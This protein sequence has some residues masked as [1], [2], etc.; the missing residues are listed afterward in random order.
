MKYCFDID[1]TIC[2]NTYGKYDEAKPFPDVIKKVNTLYDAGNKIIFFTARGTTTGIDWSE[3]TKSQLVAW[4][5]KH[6]EI[7][8]NKPDAD[9]FI[10]DKGVDIIDFMN[11]KPDSIFDKEE[12]LD[13]TYTDFKAPKSGYPF[14]L[15]KHIKKN[16]FK[17]EGTVLD[18]G[19]GFGEQLAGFEAHG[20]KPSGIDLSPSVLKLKDKFDVKVFD[21]ENSNF[22][23]PENHFDFVF[24][25][26][27]IEHMHQ[28][29]HLFD[30]ALKALKPKGKAVIMTPSWEHNMW[31]PFYIDHTHVTPFTKTS[32]EDLFV[33]SGF[34]NVEVLHFYQLPFVW[35]S[36]IFRIIPK[37]ISKLPIKYSPYYK[38][39]ILP[40]ELNKLVRFSNEVMLFGYGEKE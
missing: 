31:G 39:T 14:K 21:L 4:G 22:P 17:T 28:P 36:P 15:I 25:K 8:L 35:Q 33:M 16:Y 29:H 7:I 26:S 18:I 12:Y 19:C 13:T 37:I 23:Y 34:K 6:H 30:H 38:N 20:Y 11:E 2:N 40:N 9:L 32:L 10:D 27:V 3:L 5:V 24:S 1:G